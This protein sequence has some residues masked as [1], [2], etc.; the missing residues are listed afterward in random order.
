MGL[1]RVLI[2]SP[3]AIKHVSTVYWGTCVPSAITQITVSPFILTV[4]A[5]VETGA[6]SVKPDS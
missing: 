5:S 6:A 1:L 4:A 2:L 3:S